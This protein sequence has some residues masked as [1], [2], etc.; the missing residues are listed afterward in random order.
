MTRNVSINFFNIFFLKFVGGNSVASHNRP[1]SLWVI[2][3]K[4]IP[5]NPC[6]KIFAF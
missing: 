5:D 2:W 1:C 6:C 4:V 3:H